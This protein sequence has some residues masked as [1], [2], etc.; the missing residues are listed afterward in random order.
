LSC[1]RGRREHSVLGMKNELGHQT[2]KKGPRKRSG[3]TVVQR[4]LLSQR[5]AE[6]I[7]FK[8]RG[9]HGSTR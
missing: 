8:M 6:R 9:R 7:K 4:E 5:G 3:L 1:Q 2:E